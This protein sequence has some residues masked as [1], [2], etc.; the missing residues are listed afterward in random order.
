MV[1]IS[2]IAFVVIVGLLGIS[3]HE[4][5]HL[6]PAKYYG[7]EEGL[8]YTTN[9][10]LPNPAIKHDA[11]SLGRTPFLIVTLLPI[12][13]L[14]ISIPVLYLSY[15]NSSLTLFWIGLVFFIA[16]FMALF[17]DL[18]QIVFRIDYEQKHDYKY[19]YNF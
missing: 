3:L 5:L 4:L 17:T 16:G 12:G 8:V 6:A 14:P 9:T 7:V 15:L 19:M 2:N 1:T 11:E 18:L 10:L 13:M